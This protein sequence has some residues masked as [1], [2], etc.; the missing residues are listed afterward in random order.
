MSIL[1][2][3]T[4]ESLTS[5]IYIFPAVR[6]I[7]HVWY[8]WVQ[9]FL[10]SLYPFIDSHPSIVLFIHPANPPTHPPTHPPTYTS[11]VGVEKL[12]IFRILN[13]WWSHLIQLKIFFLLNVVIQLH[14]LA[15]G[16][17]G[18]WDTR[19]SFTFM[20]MGDYVLYK[21]TERNF[22]VTCFVLL[23]AV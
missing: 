14:V 2:L 17:S 9:F 23:V 6:I 1:S 3:R 7:I 11:I 19:S 10:Y 4:Y 13:F 22:E 8:F 5:R 21:N 20:G 12:Y 15:F 18:S 16:F